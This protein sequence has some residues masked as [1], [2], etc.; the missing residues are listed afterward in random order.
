MEETAL[1]FR[2]SIRKHVAVSNEELDKILSRS[3]LRRYRKGQFIVH[4]QA[5]SRKTCFLTKGAAAVYFLGPDGS[6]HVIQL[7]VEGWWFSDIFSYTYGQPALFNARAI[8]DC[9]VLEFPADDMQQLYAAIPA[10][11][12]YFLIIT[13]RAF[14]SFQQR[15]LFNLSLDAEE[16]YRRFMQQYPQFVKRF[17]QKMIASYIGISAEFLSKV[18]KKISSA[19]QSD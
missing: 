13:Q 18:R 9:E 12:S 15:T 14:A 2:E 6:E 19:G 8:E 5:L 17:P 11:Q 10:F 4:E 1:L 3:Q 16:R 7:A